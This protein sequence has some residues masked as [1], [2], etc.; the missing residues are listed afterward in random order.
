MPVI[1]AE[2]IAEQANGHGGGGGGGAAAAVPAR[3]ESAGA[4][5]TSNGL[6]K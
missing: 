5:D 3:F 4:S 6:M 2:H 1:G